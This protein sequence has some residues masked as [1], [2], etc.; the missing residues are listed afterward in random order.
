MST[1]KIVCPDCGTALVSAAAMSEGKLVDCPNCRL[2]FAVTAADVR[3]YDPT[4]RSTGTHVSE[5]EIGAYQGSIAPPRFWEKKRRRIKRSTAELLTI[6]L[7][8]AILLLIAAVVVTTY[9]LQLHDGTGGPTAPPP[10]SAASSHLTSP[11][12]TD[13]GVANSE[14]PRAARKSEPIHSAAVWR[15]RLTGVWEST[16]GPRPGLD[17]IGPVRWEFLADG[18]LLTSARDGFDERTL[19]SRWQVQPETATAAKL[20]VTGPRGA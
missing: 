4:P 13:P 9:A 3:L 7:G 5:V 2:L 10:R 6:Y 16:A 8:G 17:G 12:P 15:T 19:A 11:P 20:R 14:P 1:L 18:S